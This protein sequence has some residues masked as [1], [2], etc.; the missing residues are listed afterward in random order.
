MDWGAARLAQS[1]HC[2][3]SRGE[4]PMH[5]A[6]QSLSLTWKGLGRR[7]IPDDWHQIRPRTSGRNKIGQNRNATHPVNAILNYAY[8]VLESQVRM[9]VVA[10]GYD[11]AIGFLHSHNPDRP[12]LVF[13]LM[14]PLRPIV[15]RTVLNFVQ[16]HTFH[17]ADFTIR[18]GGVC[19]LNPKMARHVIRQAAGGFE[20]M[21]SVPIHASRIGLGRKNTNASCFR[22]IDDTDCVIRDS[23]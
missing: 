14:E 4:Q 21:I 2:S 3:E 12:A 8:A 13:D 11:P 5:T 19:R 18:S 6:W 9:Q 16:Q 15:D 10:E 7:P 22:Y 17:P 23:T 20:N 1:T